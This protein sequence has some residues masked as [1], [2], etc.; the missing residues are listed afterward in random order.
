MIRE[1]ALALE[2]FATPVVMFELPDAAALNR[3]LAALLLD[4]EQRVPSWQRSNVGGWH[5]P[6]DLAGRTEPCVRA[7]VQAI[8]EH[9]GHHVAALGDGAPQ[10]R[11]R[12]GVQGWAM[13]MRDG[14]YVAPHDHGDA[15]WSIAYYVDA[16]DALPA[17]SGQLAF[18]DPRRSGRSVPGLELAGTTFALTPKTGA[19]VIFPGWL[20]HHV[21][22]YRGQRPRICVS[23]NLTMEAAGGPPH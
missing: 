17:P 18:L 23:C 15:H 11:Y 5:S 10:P 6:P 12:Y 9:V 7:L 19:L 3:E 13:V 21:H 16:G 8:V 4:E 20:Q 22:P 1:P 14:H 2:L